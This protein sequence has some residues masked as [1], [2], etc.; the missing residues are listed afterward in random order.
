MQY[1]SRIDSI[2]LILFTTAALLVPAAVVLRHFLEIDPLV[3]LHMHW[4][5]TVIGVIF[6]LLA[7]LVTALNFYLAVIAPW[8]YKRRHGSMDDYSF[9]SGLPVIGGFFIFCAGALLPPSGA[10]GIYLLTLYGL[11]SG[12][13]PWFFYAILTENR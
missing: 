1:H 3:W 5:R 6:T 4:G 2:V 12:G 8:S 7:T 13:L 9:I 10:I 11:D